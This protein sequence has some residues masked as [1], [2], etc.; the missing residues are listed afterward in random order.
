VIKDLR[1]LMGAS[2][3]ICQ[4]PNSTKESQI[5]RAQPPD[6]SSSSSS[7]STL[8][9]GGWR[10]GDHQTAG[11]RAMAHGDRAAQWPSDT[12][13]RQNRCSQEPSNHK[14]NAG[15]PKCRAV[16]KLFEQGSRSA[17]VSAALIHCREPAYHGRIPGSQCSCLLFVSDGFGCDRLSPVDPRS[18]S[19]LLKLNV[20]KF[21]NCGLRPPKTAA[22]QHSD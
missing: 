15:S 7:V 22:D 10:Q 17:C 20:F 6:L 16:T 2:E 21:Q 12:S 4:Q 14:E 8:A 5:T 18:P 3:N 11:E 13:Q 1:D 9:S 19:A